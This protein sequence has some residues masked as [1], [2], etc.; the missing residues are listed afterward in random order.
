VEVAIGVPDGNWEV[1]VAVAAGVTAGETAAVGVPNAYGVCD[2]LKGSWGI[3]LSALPP[4]THSLQYP[5]NE[6]NSAC[7]RMVGRR[8]HSRPPII[9]GT[10]VLKQTRH[11]IGAGAGFV[12]DGY[13]L[14][15][16]SFGSFGSFGGFDGFS[17]GA[18]TT[19]LGTSG[20]AGAPSVSCGAGFGFRAGLRLGRGGLDGPCLSGFM[21]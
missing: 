13:R 14:R 10:S 16:G 18:E 17:T 11:R 2:A 9:R 6:D 8:C 15:L 20:V 12:V 21:V 4:S 5:V 1:G 7:F 3:A 19:P